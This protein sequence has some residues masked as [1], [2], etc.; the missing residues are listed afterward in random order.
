MVR[1]RRS[2]VS[3][4]ALKVAGTLA[5]ALLFISP[6]IKAQSGLDLLG[7]ESGARP[8]G[9]GDAFVAVAGDPI[10]QH[11][12]P[13]A[14][15]EAADF[16]VAFGHV[17]HWENIRFES[18]FLT[19]RESKI[20]YNFGLRLAQISDIE[21]RTIASPAPDYQFEARDVSLKFGLAAQVAEKLSIGLALGWLSESIN[22]YRGYSFNVDIGALY[23]HSSEFSFGASLSN[24]GSKLTL[25]QEKISIPT[26]LRFGASFV[27][28]KLLVSAGGL[29]ADEEFHIQTGAEYSLH[30]SFSLRAG[31]QTG[32]DSKN[33][34]AGAGFSKRDV[35]V[36]YAFVPYSNDLGSSHQFS[37]SYFLK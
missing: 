23:R 28:D 36:D 8:A 27:R 17:S 21:A 25:L 2:G 24:I 22:F 34:S 29:Y 19:F 14:T 35:R 7:V 3:N 5:L 33:F 10:S 6:T 11:Y 16:A 31:L 26:T 12:N 15:T 9:M 1:D 20:H 30:Q 37:L 13:A 4:F 18:V 32:F